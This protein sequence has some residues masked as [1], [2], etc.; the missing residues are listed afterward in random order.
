MRK[1]LF[2]RTPHSRTYRSRGSLRAGFGTKPRCLDLG[3][4]PFSSQFRPTISYRS[5]AKRCAA[6][7]KKS[8]EQSQPRTLQFKLTLPWRQSTRNICD[9]PTR[10]ISRCIP[11]STGRWSRWQNQ[12]LG[13][14]IMS[15]REWSLDFT[16]AP[17]GITIQ[18]RDKTTMR[19]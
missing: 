11:P 8:Y 7:C 9:V 12:W 3:R 1:M 5:R 16:S 6:S 2:A 10:S 15:L 18:V 17:S 13:L 19:S 14:Q 4:R